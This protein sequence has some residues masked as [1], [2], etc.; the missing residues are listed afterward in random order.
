MNVEAELPPEVDPNWRADIHAR[1]Q[2]V[3]AEI[4]R[5]YREEEEAGGSIEVRTRQPEEREP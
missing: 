3:P 2:A 1:I 4:E 5:R